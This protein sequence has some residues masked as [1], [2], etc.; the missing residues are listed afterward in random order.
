M[1]SFKINGKAVTVDADADTPLLW[2]IR[3]DAGLTGTKFGCSTRAITCTSRLNRWR[4]D[5]S[6]NTFSLSFQTAPC[7][8]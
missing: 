2:V 3:D 5:R 8:I 7:E 1:T 4:A 6:S